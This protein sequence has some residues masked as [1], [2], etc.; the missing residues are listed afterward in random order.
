MQPREQVNNVQAH[1]VYFVTSTPP[2]LV[3]QTVF[4]R[5]R[6]EEVGYPLSGLSKT[7][8]LEPLSSQLPGSEISFFVVQPLSLPAPIFFSQFDV[9]KRQQS[10]PTRLLYQT[11]YPTLVSVYVELLQW[12]PIAKLTDLEE[13][14][15][16]PNQTH[17]QTNSF[18]SSYQL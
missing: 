17:H 11:L 8:D 12:P 5:S 1:P 7:P 6:Y 18:G 13:T 14:L 15:T 2:V 16:L 9:E 4:D 3:I 10:A